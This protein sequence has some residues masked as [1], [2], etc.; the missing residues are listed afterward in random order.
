MTLG[1]LAGPKLDSVARLL[2]NY[3]LSPDVL[4]PERDDNDRFLS[5]AAR[6]VAARTG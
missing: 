2:R 1:I 4:G 6:P 3:R 5:V